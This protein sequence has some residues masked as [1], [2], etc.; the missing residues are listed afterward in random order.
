MDAGLA[1]NTKVKLN[2]VEADRY[3]EA[4]KR[5]LMDQGSKREVV[6]QCVVGDGTVAF[7]RK[8]KRYATGKGEPAP[9]PEQVKFCRLR[10]R[11]NATAD[12][13]LAI[14]ETRSWSMAKMAYNNL[15]GNK[16]SDTDHSPLRAKAERFEVVASFVE[17][18]PIQLEMSFTVL[19]SPL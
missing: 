18:E 8:V 10:I 7:M 15:A 2:L 13:A 1:R 11:L 19:E 16:I 12:E 6:E 4:W 14:L 17:V 9:T 5:T 3:E